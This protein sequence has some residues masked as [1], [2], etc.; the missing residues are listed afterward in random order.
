[1][2]GGTL[3]ILLGTSASPILFNSNVNNAGS[4]LLTSTGGAVTFNGNVANSGTFSRGNSA[5]TTASM[6]FG[7]PFTFSSSNNFTSYGTVIVSGNGT[8]TGAGRLFFNRTFT[9]SADIT[10]TNEVN[11]S[12]TGNLNGSNA[13]STLINADGASLTY[14]GANL[15]MGSGILDASASNN[16]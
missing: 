9:M 16:T 14:T 13:G 5:P 12:V 10:L 11:M 6:T 3:Q 7:G 4:L 1:N 8:C 15:L 2:S